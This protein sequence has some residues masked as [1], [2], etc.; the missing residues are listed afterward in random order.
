MLLFWTIRYPDSRDRQFKNR[1]LW[2]DT[3][4]LDAVT[5]AAVEATYD[6]NDSSRRPMLRFRALFREE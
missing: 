2:L 1:N 3:D 5:E 4:A 6:S